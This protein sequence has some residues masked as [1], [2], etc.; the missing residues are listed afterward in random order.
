MIQYE[1]ACR[2]CPRSCGADRENGKT[3]FCGQTSKVKI[4]RAA[5]HMWEEPCISGPEGSGTIFFSGCPLGCRFCQNAEISVRN[6]GVEISLEN[7]AEKML[8]L[9]NQH[10]NNINLVTPTHFVPQVV[11][12]VALARESGLQIPV[13]YNTSGYETPETIHLLSG[14]VD[15]YLPD[16]KYMDSGLAE[17]YSNAP[18][19]PK[20]AKLAL[21]EMVS[22]TKG[23]NQFNDDGMMVKGIIVR[24]L[25]LP[26]HTRD[27][28]NVLKYLYETY[29]DQ[30]YISIMSQYTPMPA[31]EQDPDLCRKITRREY[32]RVVDYA[33][34]LGITQAFIQ[35]GETAKESFIPPF[36]ESV[37]EL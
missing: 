37:K 36:E 6:T 7:L 34:E 9:Q 2:L 3:G 28:R 26:G 4:A 13:V 16:F 17:K 20:W 14:T 21:D 29:G 31:M 22:Q 8:W 11:R 19:Y 5:L 30:I 32:D 18:D 25:V 10:A 1:T 27:S 23:N 12:A 35:E 24:H 15:I 33:I